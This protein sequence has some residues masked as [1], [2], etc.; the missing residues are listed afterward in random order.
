MAYAD[1]AAQFERNRRPLVFLDATV[2]VRFEERHAAFLVERH[3]ADIHARRVE[4]GGGQAHALG[5]VLFADDG[6]HNALAAVDLIDFVA[7]LEDIVAFPRAEAL[8]FGHAD[9][10]LY[11]IAL[12]LGFVQKGLVALGVFLHAALVAA[13]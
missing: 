1:H 2:V 13:G 3:G 12:G 7:R 9:N 10:L 8:F 11:R 6:Q 5:N 4:V